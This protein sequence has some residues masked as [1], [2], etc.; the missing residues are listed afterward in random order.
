M[1]VKE[2]AARYFMIPHV[3]AAQWVKSSPRFE[4]EDYPQITPIT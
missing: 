3:N 2:K 1:K 4:G